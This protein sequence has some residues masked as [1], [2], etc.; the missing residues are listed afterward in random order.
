V[1]QLVAAASEPREPPWTIDA[2]ANLL[3]ALVRGQDA[4]RALAAPAAWLCAALLAFFAAALLHPRA[5]ERH[6]LSEP[7]LLRRRRS[8]WPRTAAAAIRGK[9]FAQ[10]LQ[11]PGAL[12]G[13]LVF[14][15]LVFAMVREQVLVRPILDN[16]DLPREVAHLGAL[17]SHWFIAVLLVLYA[18]MGRLVLWDGAQWSLYV[19]APAGA[20]SIL[21]GKLQ[22][23]G[24]LL[25]WPLVLVGAFGTQQ[26]A[27]SAACV[28][29]YV[30]MALAGTLVALGVLAVVGTSP[31]LMRPD[32]GGHIVQGGRTFVAAMLLVVLFELAVAPGWL[33]WIWLVAW[34]D[35]RL[36]TADAAR[37]HAPLVVAGAFAF[38]APVAA[39]GT[40]IGTRNYRRLLRP[41]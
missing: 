32:Q 13:F 5:V 15:F 6:L 41:A 24:V 8:A 26:H 18:H 16:R 23:I 14:A 39:L 31:R 21:R 2:A 10:L 38:A 40:W 22:A 29:T 3:V 1:Q 20:W 37:A 11:Q 35:G 36:V 4:A 17:L 33:S 19:G 28:L 25:L 30:G 7:P 34:A 27:A 12:I 9:E